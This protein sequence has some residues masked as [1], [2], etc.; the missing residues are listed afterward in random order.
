[1]SYDQ[2]K[3]ALKKAVSDSK[4][5]HPSLKGITK[6]Y[7]LH[8]LL[9]NGTFGLVMKAHSK[10]NKKKVAIK[11]IPDIFANELLARSVL[12]EIQTLK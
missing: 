8:K 1:M 12:R 2:M 11:F 7:T 9:G 3:N 10:L 5:V 4:T 6:E